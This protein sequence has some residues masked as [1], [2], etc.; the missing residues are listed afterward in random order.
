[1]IH[2]L[3]HWFNI[4]PVHKGHSPVGHH[5]KQMQDYEIVITER[6]RNLANELMNYIWNDKKSGIPIGDYNHLIDGI[7][8]VFITQTV[9]PMFPIK[10]N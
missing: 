3:R 10:I 8:Y 4:W 6:S 9:R 5:L 2:K 7:R 1:M